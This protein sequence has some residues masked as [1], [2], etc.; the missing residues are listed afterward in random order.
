MLNVGGRSTAGLATAAAGVIGTPT[1]TRRLVRGADQLDIVVE[2][3]D[4]VV[5][6]D[7]N[8]APS[9]PEPLMRLTFGSQHTT[10]QTF[11]GVAPVPPTAG[12]DHIAAGDSVVVVPVT[13]PFPFTLD[14]VLDAATARLAAQDSEAPP[15]GSVTAVEVPAGLVLT[16]A[17]AARLVAARRPF[18]TGDTTEVWTARVEPAG[19]SPTLELA[20]VHHAA[21]PAAAH[22]GPEATRTAAT[23][24]PTASPRPRS[25]PGGCGSPAPAPSPTSTASGPAASPTTTTSSPPAGT[26][27]CRSSS[28][29]TSCRSATGP[30]SPRCRRGPSSTTPPARTRP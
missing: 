17:G 14:G 15:D 5:D 27:T 13:G 22:P 1:V 3:F 28:S 6:G 21:R 7:G 19:G 23:S 18:T 25:P 16:P 24:S 9:G 29:A 20:A 4:A 10:E 11:R 2:L 8:V 26:P 12:I 30:R